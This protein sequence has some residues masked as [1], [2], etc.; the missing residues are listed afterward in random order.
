[1]EKR[2]TVDASKMAECID[3][4]KHLLSEFGAERLP[5]IY[6]EFCLRLCDVIAGSEDLN[7]H[8]GRVDIWAAAIV[9]AIARLN[10]LFSPETPNCLSADEICSRFGVKKEP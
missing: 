1:M 9:Y 5:D 4:T 8:L 7:L 10:F 2:K 6:A 3:Q